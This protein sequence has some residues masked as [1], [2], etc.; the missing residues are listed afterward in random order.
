M[1]EWCTGRGL[2]A[3]DCFCRRRHSGGPDKARFTVTEFGITPEELRRLAGLVEE[4]GLSELRYES[5]EL[6]VT[7]R[8]AEYRAGAPA[9][10]ALVS[11]PISHLASRNGPDPE[12][13]SGV[14]V[15]AEDG[16]PYA[17]EEDAPAAGNLVRIEAPVMGVF[18]R[19]PAP[20]EPSFVDVGDVVEIGQPIGVIEAMKVFSE[21]LAESAGRVREIPVKNGALVQP[22]DPLVIL[23]GE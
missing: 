5:G 22:G 10:M 12:W 16:G 13:A 3:S 11:S 18:Y 19:S 17:D 23:E 2:A 14:D 6:C 20:G 15:G 21:V 4:H 9:Q 7:L 8:T 1:L